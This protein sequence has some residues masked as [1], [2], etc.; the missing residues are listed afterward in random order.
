MAVSMQNGVLLEWYADNGSE[1]IE[2]QP[3]YSLEIEKT[4]VD[5][6]APA[7]GILTCTGEEGE[8]Y[9]V[10]AVIGEITTS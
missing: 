9:P 3:L 10:G 6:E 5:V 1:V 4:A 7:T 2:G 8:T